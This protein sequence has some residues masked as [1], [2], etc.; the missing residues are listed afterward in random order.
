[1]SWSRSVAC[2]TFL[3][4]HQGR[5]G[6]KPLW[7]VD[8]EHACVV[9]SKDDDVT[10]TITEVVSGLIWNSSNAYVLRVKKDDDILSRKNWVFAMKC[11]FTAG[12]TTNTTTTVENS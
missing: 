10:I 7:S 8:L 11:Q 6:M 1:M 12:G 3:S 9:A 5:V 4:V 2:F